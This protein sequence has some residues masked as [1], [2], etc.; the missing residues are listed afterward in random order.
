MQVAVEDTGA[1]CHSSYNLR[2][3]K[4]IQKFKKVIN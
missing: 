3:G 1:S 4:H 2:F